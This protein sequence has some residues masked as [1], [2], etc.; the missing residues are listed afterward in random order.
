MQLKEPMKLVGSVEHMLL[1]IIILITIPILEHWP[2]PGPIIISGG[3]M[4]RV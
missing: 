1:I 3:R 4:L 2:S